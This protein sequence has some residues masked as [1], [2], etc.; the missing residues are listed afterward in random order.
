MQTVAGYHRPPMARIARDISWLIGG[1]P[2]VELRRLAPGSGGRLLVKLES[3]NPTG[4]NKD[5]AARAMI[6]HAERSGFLTEGSTVIEC[7]AGDTGVSLAM[8]CAVRG[9]RLILTMPEGI[10]GSRTNLLRALGAELEFTDAE[11]G[12]RGALERAEQL[13]REID[14]SMILQPFSNAANAMAHAE[15][16]A[17]EIWWDTDGE[18]DFVV[19]PVGSG[20]TAAGCLEFFRQTAP[21]VA[22]V[23]VEPAESAV[24]SGRPAGPHR[25]PGLGAGFVPDILAPGDLDE[26][27]PVH[28]T[29]AFAT[30]REIAR[31]E[32]LL[33]GP[34]S[35]A[36]LHAARSIAA[37]DSSAS[38]TVVAILPDH[39][40]RYED[41]PAYAGVMPR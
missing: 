20:G 9:Y 3:F 41:H 12:I 35:G 16:T 23:G 10:G 11:L 15:T 27:I 29:D 34:A 17:R 28:E 38:R 4:S 19:C 6:E 2:L 21:E 1:T 39:G 33:V 14:D 22:V 18:V 40:E 36:V 13:Q 31:V 30:V 37:R 7:S 25:L 26:V 24:L 8:I 5:R 32:G